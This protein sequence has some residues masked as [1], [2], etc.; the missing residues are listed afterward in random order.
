M[1]VVMFAWVFFRASSLQHASDY[2]L[3]LIGHWPSGQSS[4]AWESVYSPRVGLLIA[5]ATLL[6]VGAYGRLSPMLRPF[7]RVLSG[8]H[9]DGWARAVP[10]ASMLIASLMSIALGKYNPFIYFRF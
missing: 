2:L 6:A 8:V 9:C 5:A 4:V 10:V 7:W 3:A 1:L